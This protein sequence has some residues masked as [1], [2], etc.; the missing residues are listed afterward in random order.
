MI[1]AGTVWRTGDGICEFLE[2]VEVGK[3][4]PASAVLINGEH[5]KTS[6]FVPI[7]GRVVTMG[8]LFGWL[9]GV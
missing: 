2:D 9:D 6:I 8:E 3:P 1:K 5:P 7:G 4:A